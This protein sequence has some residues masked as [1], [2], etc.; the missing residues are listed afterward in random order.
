[1]QP[2]Y[3]DQAPKPLGPYTQGIRV[4]DWLFVSGQVPVDPGTAMLV[5]G[6][7]KE[8][9]ARVLLNLQAVIEAAGGT[10]KQVVQT[11]VYMTDLKDFPEFNHLYGEFF[12]PPY[13]ARA[14]VQVAA[15][16]AG[17]RLE[18]SATADLGKR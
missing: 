1:M 5:S 17:A 4:G 9:V 16:P 2:I 7:L 18:I 14:V 15:L 3:T 8:Q 13:P 12:S 6:G 10:L 11:T